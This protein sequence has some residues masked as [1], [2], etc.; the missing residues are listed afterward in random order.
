MGEWGE[1]GQRTRAELQQRPHG[2]DL[3]RAAGVA[4]FLARVGLP[5]GSAQ[6]CFVREVRKV[7]VRAVIDQQ[8][9]NVEVEIR[10]RPH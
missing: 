7:D 3:P 6:R 1:G 4:G 10:R 9:Y 5:A 8:L 2:G